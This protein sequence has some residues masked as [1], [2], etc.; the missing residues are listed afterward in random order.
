[1]F[2]AAATTETSVRDAMVDQIYAYASANLD[3][4]PFPAVYS[5]NNASQIGGASR[6]VSLLAL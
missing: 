3:T 6:Y 1:M 2:A 5:Q 4:W